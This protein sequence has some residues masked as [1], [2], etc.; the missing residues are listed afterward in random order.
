MSDIQETNASEIQDND[1]Q[2]TEQE[3]V[4]QEQEQ[5]EQSSIEEQ[6][7]TTSSDYDPSDDEL[8]ALSDEEFDEWV[9]TNKFPDS[10]KI[11]KSTSKEKEDTESEEQVEEESTPDTSTE[12]KVGTKPK[13][14]TKQATT[15][16]PNIDYKAFYEKIFQPFKA[17]GKEIIPR[18]VDDIITLMQQGAN[19]TKKMQQLAPLRRSAE[20]LVQA[21]IDNNRLAFLIDLH[22]GNKN[23]IKKLLK[24]NNIDLSEIDLTEENDYT[25][26]S[27]NIASDDDIEF[28]DAILDSKDNLPRIKDILDN[29]WDKKSKELVLKDPK[30]LKGLNTEIQI[31]RFDYVQKIL[32]SEKVFGRYKGKSDIEAYI[33]LIN[34]L[35][36]SQNEN[37]TTSKPSKSKTVNSTKQTNR[38]IPKNIDKTKAAPTKSKATSTKSR[39]TPEDLL[40]MPEEEFLKLN[41]KDL[42]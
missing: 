4:V 28:Q 21:G 40:N 25:P 8:A 7:T 36:A 26:T 17:N 37:N 13:K 38:V 34:A 23:A 11:K 5:E 33:E 6:V 30:L 42:E 32:E 22:N 27:R 12:E 16:N 41:Y 10:K 1:V 14:T 35:I 39:Y 19:Y 15:V 29:V 20:S 2:S 18:D 24:D 3:E 9:A 31:G